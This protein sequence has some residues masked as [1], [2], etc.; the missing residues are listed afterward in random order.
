M[1]AAVLGGSETSLLSQGDS[2]PIGG[3]D[4]SAR[5]SAVEAG[6]IR[7]VKV[8]LGRRTW[9]TWAAPLSKARLAP[10]HE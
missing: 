8:A 10:D 6:G 4:A 2:L 5:W 1:E 3:A 7:I 9:A